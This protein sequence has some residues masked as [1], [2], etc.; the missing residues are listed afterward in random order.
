MVHVSTTYCNIDRAVNE[1]VVYP[2]HVD[3]RHIIK[4]AESED[5]ATA[6]ILHAK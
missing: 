6:Q 2:A 3:W 5:P 1:E 4:I